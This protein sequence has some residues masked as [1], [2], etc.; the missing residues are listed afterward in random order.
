M[1]PSPAAVAI[2]Q[3]FEGLRLKPYCCSG[4]RW[5]IGYGHTGGIAPLTPEIT[6]ETAEALLAG[7]LR[8]VAAGVE[9]LIKVPVTQGQF[10]ALVSLAFNC[11][12]DAVARS[13][14]L[15]KLNKGDPGG[16]AAEFAKWNRAKGVVLAG[17]VKRRAAEQA[18]FEE[19]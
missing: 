12:V 1:I 10:D 5:T 19:V 11:G 8:T 13:T 15:R 2:I 3:Q 14:L 9:R 16:A 7:D 6:P 17:L 18:L 4:G